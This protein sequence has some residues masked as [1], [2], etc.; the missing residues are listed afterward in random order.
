MPT[1]TAFRPEPSCRPLT[2]VVCGNRDRCGFREVATWLHALKAWHEFSLMEYH[3]PDEYFSDASG[4]STSI[5]MF[6]VFQEYPGQFE[7]ATFDRL[8]QRSPLARIVLL[9][10]SLCRGELRTGHP[11]SISGRFYLDQWNCFGR[12]WFEMFLRGEA[13][14]FSLPQTCSDSDIAKALITKSEKISPFLS[15]LVEC[16]S[17]SNSQAATEVVVVAQSDIELRRFMVE[18]CSNY[19]RTARRVTFKELCKWTQ[20]P[21][22][23]VIDSVDLGDKTFRLQV[24]EIIR[25]FPHAAIR[26]LAFAPHAEEIAA[27][28][29]LPHC[30]VIGKPF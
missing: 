16:N 5:D 6:L 29:S 22:E 20:E 11:A 14:Y 25:R 28:E 2:V 24:E 8:R 1:L 9:L 17:D 10:D 13:G 7:Q 18:L 26:V 15:P 4:Q 27:Y 3:S 19:G 23:V 21:K 12:D 30:R